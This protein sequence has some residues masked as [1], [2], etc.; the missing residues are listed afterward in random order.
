MS[1]SVTPFTLMGDATGGMCVGDAC[2]VPP[3][4]PQAIVN[5]RLDED[6]V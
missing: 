3:E 2:E 6:S 4:A 1:E 5:R